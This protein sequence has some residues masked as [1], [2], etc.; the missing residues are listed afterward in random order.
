M[1]FARSWLAL[2]GLL[3]LTGSAFADEEVTTLIKRLKDKDVDVRSGAAFALGELGEEAKEAVPALIQA[4]QDADRN[5][6]FWSAEALGKIGAPAVP[7]LAEAL[8]DKNAGV[9]YGAAYALAK[10]G[11]EAKAAVGA[12]SD[13]LKADD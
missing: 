1:L 9:R 5:A 10:M 6:R 12:L 13:A 4:L 2:L 11:A 7:A 8:K 3:C